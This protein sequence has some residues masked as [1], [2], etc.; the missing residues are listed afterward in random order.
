MTALQ[1]RRCTECGRII[2]RDPQIDHIIRKRNSLAA[3]NDICAEC[4]NKYLEKWDLAGELPPGPY[5][6]LLNVARR[7][8]LLAQRMGLSDIAESAKFLERCGL[9]SQGWNTGKIRIPRRQRVAPISD[10][11]TLITAMADEACRIRQLWEF[12]T[13][14]MNP[15]FMVDNQILLTYARKVER[16][17]QLFIE[18]WETTDHATLRQSLGAVLKLARNYDLR[19]EMDIGAAVRYTLGPMVTEAAMFLNWLHER[20]RGPETVL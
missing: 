11:Q 6:A 14:Y 5:D 16:N 19:D 18:W 15:E 4:N 3:V 1:I 17:P 7:T 12:L 10:H 9:K 20:R 13:P 2:T 8:L